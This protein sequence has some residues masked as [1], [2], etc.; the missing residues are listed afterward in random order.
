MS[1]S[2]R[3]TEAPLLRRAAARLTATVDLPTPPLPDA[4]AIVCL[5]PGRISDGLGRRKAGRT[6]AVIR[7]ST[8]VTPASWPTASSACDLK[9]SRTGHAGVVSSKVK[10]TRPCWLTSI[11][12]IMPRLTTSRPRSGSLIVAS[13]S[14]TCCELGP[15]IGNRML[16]RLLTSMRHEAGWARA[17]RTSNRDGGQPCC[18]PHRLLRRTGLRRLLPAGA[19]NAGRRP[20]RRGRGDGFLLQQSRCP[21]R[22]RRGCPLAVWNP[23][24]RRPGVGR[25]RRRGHGE[26]GNRASGPRPLLTLRRLRDSP[27]RHA[28]E[29][30]RLGDRGT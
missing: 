13:A 21:M 26:Q 8:P 2:S 11:S 19:H 9:R 29:L 7:T 28:V 12:L 5:T 17:G 20:R 23:P 27:P 30:L 25:R 22:S 18:R 24:G 10:L 14:S 6:L 4:T 15:L 16:P 3:P 1:A